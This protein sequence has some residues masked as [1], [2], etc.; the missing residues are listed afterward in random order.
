MGKFRQ[1]PVVVEANQFFIAGQWPDGVCG[2]TDT[3]CGRGSYPHVHTL[4][5]TSYHLA[6]GDWIITGIKG[7]RYPCKPDIFEMTYEEA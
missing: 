4:E 1:K 5:G 6:D 3:R 7:G 2:G